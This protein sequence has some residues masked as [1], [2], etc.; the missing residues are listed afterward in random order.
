M[1]Q[2]YRIICTSVDKNVTV[3]NKKKSNQRRKIQDEK[4]L[5]ITKNGVGSVPLAER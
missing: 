2:N 1:S 3:R 5:D 4:F